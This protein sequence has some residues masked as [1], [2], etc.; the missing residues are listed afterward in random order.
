MNDFSK[1]IGIPFKSCGRNYSG[2]DCWGLLRL[3]YKEMLDI[4]L[5]SYI[6]EYVD[7]FNY[8]VISKVIVQH[9]SEW[10]KVDHGTEQMFDVILLDLRGLPIHVGMV[11]VPGW[12]L[13]IKTKVNSCLERYNTTLWNRRIRGFYRY[14]SR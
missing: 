1:Y 14:E 5:S 8:P 6:D 2:I 12:M 7:S 13:H 4:T 3:V 10:I 9:A 11:I